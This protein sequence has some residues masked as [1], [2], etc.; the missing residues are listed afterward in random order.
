MLPQSK[1]FDRVYQP[2]FACQANGD[3]MPL[4]YFQ[5]LQYIFIQN[6]VKTKKTTPCNKLKLRGVK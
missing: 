3:F 5:C 1:S 6:N 4:F 2:G